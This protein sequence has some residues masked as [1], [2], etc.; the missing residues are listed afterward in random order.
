[1]VFFFLGSVVL[2]A[3]D[4]K[5]EQWKG[6]GTIQRV[7]TRSVPV[8][9]QYKT[10]FDLGNGIYCSN[11]F[12][13]ARMNGVVLTDDTLIT[14]LITSENAPI[15]SSPWYA[16]KLWADQEKEV[17]L[18]LTYASGIGNRY[19]PKLSRDGRD[20][21]VIEKDKFVSAIMKDGKKTPGAELQ[22]TI[23][24]DT[25]WVAGQEFHA[26]PQIDEWMGQLSSRS[27]VK[28]GVAGK[29]SEGRDIP[30]MKIGRGDSRKMIA[31][32]GR[33]HPPEVSGYLAMQAFV[34]TI[35]SDSELAKRFREAY[36][37]YVFPAAN[38]DGIAHGHW[39]HNMGGID[40][41]RDWFLFNQP[42]TSAI[43]DYVRQ[44]VDTTNKQLM[45]F[46]DFHSTKSDIYYINQEE[47]KGNMPGAARALIEK[48]DEAFPE[49]KPNVR[50]LADENNTVV[51]ADQ[52][53][54]Y[55]FGAES[56]T[57]EVGDNTS[58]EF[59]RQKAEVTA[60]IL[61]ELLLK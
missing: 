3:Q 47:G 7:N 40:L 13:G 60:N 2:S 25:L 30:V 57:Y 61:M 38:P 10:I 51:T 46:I 55:A 22:L 16:F 5:K 23:G 39:R 32:M 14:V 31:V 54:A 59:I 15:N 52:Y 36:D 26:N 49:Y 44:L 48:T 21:Q 12:D 58:R 9:L 19:I 4:Q 29:S 24:P 11:N 1:M 18:R 45:F 35:C 50:S 56:L 20:W 53:F 37:L 17:T 28:E 42:E 43:R 41:N 6:Q 34:E 8:Q 27:F 33:Q